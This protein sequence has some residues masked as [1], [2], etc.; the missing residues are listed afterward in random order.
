[1]TAPPPRLSPQPL[2]SSKMSRSKIFISYSHKDKLWLERL[3]EHLGVAPDEVALDL[4]DDRRIAMGDEWLAEITRAIDQ[5]HAAILLVSPSFLVS[6]FIRGVEV[7]RLLERRSKDGL[8]IFPVLIRSCDWQVTPWLSSLQIRPDDA[9]PLDLLSKARRDFFLAA[10]SREVRRILGQPSPPSRPVQPVPINQP[11]LM[12]LHQIS[13]PP[14]DFTGREAE[15]LDL[16]RLVEQGGVVIVGMGGLGKTT[17]AEKLAEELRP[18]Y[19][20]A[21]IYLDLKGVAPTPLS[22]TEAMAH[23]VRTFHPEATVP[24]GEAEL[25]SLYRSVLDGKRAL[26][27]MD[28]AAGR[29]QVEPLLPPRCCLLLVTSRFHFHVPGLVLKDLDELPEKDACDLL[30]HIAP[31]LGDHAAEIARLCGR[32]PI[33]LRLAGG[34]LAERRDLS[35]A[36]YVRR[37]KDAQKRLRLIDSHLSLSYDLLSEDLQRRWRALGVFPGTFDAAAAAAVWGVEA[38]PADEVLGILVKSSL[39]DGEDGRY[40]LHDLA[41]VFAES[42]LDEVEGTE[43]RYRHAVYYGRVL[44]A[45]DDLYLEGGESVLVGLRLYD[46]EWGNIQAGFAWSAEGAE[47]DEAAAKLCSGYLT[48][49]EC[50]LGLRQPKR[51]QIHWLDSALAAARRLED[52]S[53]EGRHL[54][55]LGLAYAALGDVRRAIEHYKQHLRIAREIGDRPGEGQALGSLG[56]AYAAFGDARRA[57]EHY[58][59]WH[60]ITR[61]IGNRRGEGQA[62]GNLGLAYA[63]LGDACRA[64]GYYEQV[65]QITREIG[66]RRGESNALGNLGLAYAALGDARRAIGYYEQDLQIAREIGDRRGEGQALGNLGNSYAALGDAR[67]AIGYYEQTLQIAREVGDRRSEGQTLGNL[68][69][70]YLAFGDAHR[71]ME[72]YDQHLQTSREIGD[73]RGEGQALGNLGLAY[74]ALGDAHR[75]IEFH[76]QRLQIARDIGDRRGEGQALGSLGLAYAYLGDAHRA[77]EH[78][79][80]DLQIA[81]E[82]GDRAGEARASWNLGL[83][84]EAEGDLR[85]AAELMQCWIEYVREIGHQEAETWAAEVE[86]IRA[87]IEEEKSRPK[88]AARKRRGTSK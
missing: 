32:L 46:L 57:I 47:A 21:Q 8:R 62:L 15:L 17:L 33:A 86:A 69:N 37:L 29:E 85:L 82:I 30:L 7:P 18:E 55:K 74:A 5:A 72:H 73:R 9:K 39:V 83:W 10:I 88:K 28:N 34:A 19:P 76:E 77:I 87:R 80:Q 3:V 36:E 70:A 75:A 66:D 11:L 6:K 20:D 71:A 52:R 38:D 53:A 43:A 26:L 2:E 24:A 49:G 65:L 50:C 60:Q 41:R 51:E 79:E 35:P 81:R 40:R 22:A 58:E 16:H 44:N 68:G 14:A 1:M 12:L 13:A 56:L 25:R 67:R 54:G 78:Y 64:I 63:A 84:Y 48:A 45:A 42:R 27:L 59:Q 61:E 23:V 31:R 4:W